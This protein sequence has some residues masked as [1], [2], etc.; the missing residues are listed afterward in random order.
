VSTDPEAPLLP[1][2]DEDPEVWAETEH[3]EPTEAEIALG[4]AL[5]INI[6]PEDDLDAGV[7]VMEGWQP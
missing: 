5:G 7:D 3:P 6:D 1:V 4:N 2:L